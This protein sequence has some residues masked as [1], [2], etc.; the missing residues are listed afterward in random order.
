[1]TCD[2]RNDFIMGEVTSLVFPMVLGGYLPFFI[3]KIQMKKFVRV[4]Y[5]K[6]PQSKENKAIGPMF[7]HKEGEIFFKQ[8]KM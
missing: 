5:Y 8:W 7:G 6:Y 2:V 3:G 1:M 4:D